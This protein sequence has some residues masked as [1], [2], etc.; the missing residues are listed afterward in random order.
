MLM[1]LASSLMTATRM[2]GFAHAGAA[3]GARRGGRR[4]GRSLAARALARLGRLAG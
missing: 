1:T 4:S 2:D 3:T